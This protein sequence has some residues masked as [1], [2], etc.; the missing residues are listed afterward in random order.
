MSMQVPFC[1]M[2]KVMQGSNE[3]N[4]KIDNLHW[5]CRSPSGTC[6]A[7]CWRLKLIFNS[8]NQLHKMYVVSIAISL[9]FKLFYW[10]LRLF[11][12]PRTSWQ[13]LWTSSEVMTSMENSK[14][15]KNS[16]KL[17]Q[18]RGRFSAVSRD[19]CDR[20]RSRSR[21]RSFFVWIFEFWGCPDLWGLYDS[22]CGRPQ[23]TRQPWNTKIPTKMEWN[24]AIEFL[25][26]P[27]N[28]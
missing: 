25:H 28:Y 19:F 16:F 22:L 12:P 26:T 7:A 17:E 6:I 20:N 9:F 1:K 23:R 18:K 27:A 10:V 21:F 4:E 2:Q 8:L 5:Q 15:Y 14:M 11:W 13:L 24:R 3:L